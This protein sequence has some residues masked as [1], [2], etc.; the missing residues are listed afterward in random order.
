MRIIRTRQN[1]S[2]PFGMD[3]RGVGMQRVWRMCAHGDGLDSRDGL[4]RSERPAQRDRLARSK[5][6]RAVAGS[7]PGRLTSC[8]ESGSHHG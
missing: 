6:W 7:L 1:D 4:T 2:P 3:W 8:N 5:G